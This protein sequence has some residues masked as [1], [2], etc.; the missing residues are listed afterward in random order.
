MRRKRIALVGSMLLAA[1]IA[2]GCSTVP[3]TPVAA[4]DTSPFYAALVDLLTQPVAHYTGSSSQGASWD[5]R[6]TSGGEM[7]GAVT[8]AGQQ[9]TDVL[10]VDGKTYLKPPKTALA[11]NLPR[12]MTSASL[13][14]KWVTGSDDLAAVVPTGAWSPRE[15]ALTLLRGLDQTTDFP[16]AGA[17]TVQV[18][19]D[20]GIEVGTPTGTLAVS[21]KAPHRL[22]RWI[23][24]APSAATRTSTA[25]S[26]GSTGSGGSAG[27]ASGGIATYGTDGQLGPI[28]FPVV[29][30]ADR[31]QTYNDLASQAQ[32]LT[33]A[34]NLGV[35]FDFDSKGS[36]KCDNSSCTVTST[37]TTKTTA[38]AGARL[39]GNISA[40]MKASVA[41][42]GTPSTG[43]A[44]TQS[45]P[46]NGSGVMTCVD[47]GVAALVSAIRSR[48]Q[49]EADAKARA[50]NRDVTVEYTINY[51]GSVD[52]QAVAM[53]QAEIDRVVTV[54]RTAQD[55]ARTR[56]SCGTN[57]SYQQAPY[58]KDQLSQAAYRNRR[59]GASTPSNNLIVALV[60]GIDPQNGDLVIGSGDGQSDN[61]TARAEED[62]LAKL[63]AKGF[64]P[65]QITGLYSERQPCFASCGTKLQGLRPE[66]PVSYSVPWVSNDAAALS[67]GNDLLQKLIAEAGGK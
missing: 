59:S 37:V 62:L 10:T 21:A 54:I 23:P 67:A 13:E 47:T 12:G 17:P 35:S 48:K 33:N 28:L 64:K 8:A 14:G 2:T 46:L 44:T 39:T 60:P 57:C 22:L 42:D 30:P 40:V 61:P 50:Q 26:G 36:L 11:S 63:T 4:P 18:G 34:V 15:L 3:G 45:L 5:L 49:A 25:G 7:V 27:G 38:T 31:E 65:D 58:N 43:C 9:K 29:T 24:A 66:T 52:I 56:S 53:V 16:R 51:T 41:V 6:A 32:T 20:Q 55:S 19:S 1:S